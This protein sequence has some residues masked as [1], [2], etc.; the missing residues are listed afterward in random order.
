MNKGLFVNFLV[1][2]PRKGQSKTAPIL[3]VVV[4]SVLH[5]CPGCGTVQDQAL[6]AEA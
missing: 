4:F 5:T 2:F 3:E 6:L 1:P